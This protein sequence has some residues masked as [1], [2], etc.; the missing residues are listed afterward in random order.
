[1]QLRNTEFATKNKLN[2]LLNKLGG[3]KFVITLVLKCRITINEDE[4]KY[5]TFYSNS[6]AETVIH[7][8]YIDN[9]FESI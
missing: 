5:S 2:N 9:V 7:D 3:F 6:K 1:M 4:T 8:T